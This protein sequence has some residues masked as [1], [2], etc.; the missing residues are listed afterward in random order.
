MLMLGGCNSQEGNP[1]AG[2][3]VKELPNININLLSI[4]PAN[5]FLEV[6]QTKQ[7]YAT[8]GKEPYSFY[9]S[10]GSGSV[11]ES[12]FYTAPSFQT[13]TVI[14]VI[15]AD[16]K[17]A[18]ATIVVNVQ[19]SMT[20]NSVVIGSNA[21]TTFTASGGIPPYVYS[22]VSGSG[23]L[24]SSTG[25][26][27]SVAVPPGTVI[28]K[29]TDSLGNAAFSA[30]TINPALIIS[31]AVSSIGKGETVQLS[32]SGGTLPYFFSNISG[33]GTGSVNSFTGLYTA[34]N[35]VATAFIR[36]TDNAGNTV[37]G[38]INVVNK[39]QI[40]PEE[41]KVAALNDLQ[42]SAFEGTPPYTFSILSGGGTINSGTG[43]YTAPAASGSVNVRVVDA[44]GYFD[45]TN[46]TIFTPPILSLGY[47]HT[48]VL[49]FSNPLAAITKCW[50]ASNIDA[51]TAGMLSTSDPK[52]IIGDNI[53]DMGDNV[54]YLN[55]GTGVL[56]KEYV[57]GSNIGCGL[58]TTNEIRCLGFGG[59]GQNLRSSGITYG[60]YSDTIGDA[61][62]PVNLGAGRTVKLTLPF[63]DAFAMYG[64][65]SC[66]IL[67]ND[68][69][70]CWGAGAGGKRGSG[71][72]AAFGTLGTET[73]DNLP[74]VNLGGDIPVKVVISGGHV[75]V[76]NNVGQLKCWGSNT[77]GQLGY[78]DVT[79]RGNTA[80]TTPNNL[81]YINLGTG[82]T[83]KSVALSDYHTCA[84]L[85]DDTVKCWGYNG[86][87]ELGLGFGGNQGDGPGEMGDT[88]P[89]LNLG[90]AHTKVLKIVANSYNTCALL[91]N[92]T[93]K[94]WG[95]NSVGQLGSG[96]V[97]S[98][99]LSPIDMGDGLLPVNLGTGRTVI[100][101][102][103]GS[104]NFCAKLDN[105]Q[106]KCWGY[107]DKA[108]LGLGHI[109][110]VGRSPLSLGDNLQ[111][112]N[113]GAGLEIDYISIGTHSGCALL[114]N[115]K[116]KCWGYFYRGDG[117]QAVGDAAGEVTAALPSVAMPTGVTFK[118]LKS[119]G[120]FTCGKTNADKLLCWGYNGT[121]TLGLEHAIIPFAH[122]PNNTGDNFIY[123]DLGTG[124]TIKD[125]S[126]SS[127]HSCAILSN[128]TL[129]CWGQSENGRV[130]SPGYKGNVANTMGDFLQPVS[131]GTVGLP[132]QISTGFT[133]NCVRFDN[134]K[135]K[136]FG[137]GI[138]GALGIGSNTDRGLIPATEMG[139][140][141]P[142][143][144]LGTARTAKN[145]CAGQY[146]SCAHLDNDSIKCWGY[147]PRIASG[148]AGNKGDVAGEMGDN[149][150]AIPF[151]DNFTP[152]K[153]VC[154][155]ISSCAISTQ[156]TMKCWGQNDNGQIP[157]GIAGIIGDSP[158]ELGNGMP[159]AS[160]GS[161]RKIID[162][163][164]NNHGCAV[165]D[166]G[167][168]KCWGYNLYGQLGLGHRSN[169]G[170]S[171]VTIGDNLPYVVFE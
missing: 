32:V 30:V 107:N 59:N 7:F 135:V 150:A 113:L 82:K 152:K 154:G 159:Y 103:N 63:E 90:T 121:G 76:I 163:A 3:G 9:L 104:N 86:N 168:V 19:I 155:M 16:L 117:N 118:E 147:G 78:G 2:F 89:A 22:I 23:T 116:V 25:I 148:V 27:S 55:F 137:Q 143:V 133:H 6:N 48:C 156:G 167:K 49:S 127:A 80:G 79:A 34:P 134:G 53:S 28:I 108:Q 96:G 165:L 77:T 5:T 102:F 62:I 92:A 169:M 128:D 110:N 138:Y 35:S 42:F 94:C 126:L 139:D 112:L 146:F 46:V 85:N 111:A 72:N 67:D 123:T 56:I 83:A 119:M 87:G 136:C 26:Y 160:L 122:N 13:N 29:A 58:T 115:Q 129:K 65:T 15:D 50:G 105:L 130:G 74:I 1:S 100:D 4:T 37:D 8:G 171:T 101:L 158:A 162:V 95:Y 33:P 43:L 57:F 70:K 114:T 52:L 45:D 71:D 60:D 69:L 145:V 131:L 149:L 61:V 21:S 12:G 161:G 54:P 91:D 109:F 141:L 73:G 18:F 20:P 66:A 88:L 36:V 39:P 38:I 24:G 164:L 142:F 51:T 132:V 40:S 153:L 10:S 81:P 99:G 151:G 144:D 170:L 68:T 84:I 75:C 17:E 97:A 157:I 166:N 11:S 64:G 140:N 31:P 124:L 41:N 47:Q 120:N 98:I 93:V 14:K 44:N 125:Y 106:V